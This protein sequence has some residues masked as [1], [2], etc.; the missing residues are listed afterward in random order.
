MQVFGDDEFPT[1]FWRYAAGL[2]ELAVIAEKSRAAARVVAG[3]ET[4]RTRGDYR[5]A[6]CRELSLEPDAARSH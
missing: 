4:A 5:A 2:R 6:A 1:G 3:V